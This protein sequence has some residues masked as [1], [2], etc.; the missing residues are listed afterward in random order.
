[1]G[2]IH[3]L[4]ARFGYVRLRDFGLILTEDRRVVSTRPAVLDDGFGARIVGWQDNDL[5]ALE[6]AKPG[7]PAAKPPPA[8]KRAAA[9][10]VA[11]PAF[12]PPKQAQVHPIAVPP[13]A[14]PPRLKI[15]APPPVAPSPAA[16]GPSPSVASARAAEPAPPEPAPPEPDEGD[17]WEWEIAA[18]RARAAAVDDFTPE[19]PTATWSEETATRNNVRIVAQ[20]VASDSPR[21]VIP[22]PTFPPAVDTR[23][24]RP[25]ERDEATRSILPQP[26]RF[27]R[28]TN[29]RFAADDHTSPTVVSLPSRAARR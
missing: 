21:T 12:P 9:M 16:V 3:S 28:A 22:V 4:L 27:P 29:Q 7:E 25:L 15:V 14:E 20:P 23:L 24:V 2:A 8:P 1:M 13:V 17:D 11:V 6:L 18:A 26:R 19:P 5:A 10:A